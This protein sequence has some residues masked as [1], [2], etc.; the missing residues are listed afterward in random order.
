MGWLRDVS[1][2]CWRSCWTIWGSFEQCWWLSCDL[3][4]SRGR[5]GLSW[6][7][8]HRRTPPV[9][10]PREGLGGGRTLSEG[11][12]DIGR[13]RPLSHARPGGS[14]DFHSR[15]AQHGS[16]P[17]PE[18]HAHSLAYFPSLFPLRIWVGIHILSWQVLM[19]SRTDP[20]L[21]IPLPGPRA[22][23]RPT[24]FFS[25]SLPPSSYSAAVA[26]LA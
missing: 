15:V 10:D 13:T 4:P 16:R 18:H 22:H 24:P 8:E 23:P 21:A 11:E 5:C 1:E 12:G 2:A 26:S 6:T 14:R 17:F 20:P 19:C 3:G 7:P 25:L 9:S